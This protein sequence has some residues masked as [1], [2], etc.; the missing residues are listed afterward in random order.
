MRPSKNSK[1]AQLLRN[2][3]PEEEVR[4]ELVKILADANNNLLEKEQLIRT[5]TTINQN[6]AKIEQEFLNQQIDIGL[7]RTKI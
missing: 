7:G 4:E 3:V 5:R 1:L 6:L 2:M